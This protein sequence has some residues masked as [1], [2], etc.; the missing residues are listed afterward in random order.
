M[1]KHTLKSCGVNTARLLKY[2]WPF[3]SIVHERVNVTSF[4]HFFAEINK[5]HSLKPYF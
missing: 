4:I 3:Y 2:V 1:A 5:Y